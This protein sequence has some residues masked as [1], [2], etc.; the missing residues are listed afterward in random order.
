MRPG[1]KLS[2]LQ[3]FANRKM[4]DHRQHDAGTQLPALDQFDFHSRL[5]DA[6]GPVLVMFTSPDC[7]GCRHLRGV[8]FEVR[9]RHPEWRYFEVDAQRDQALTNEFEV[10]HLPTLFLFHAGQFH[11][12][13]ETEA[14]P[15]AIIAAIRAALR[16][17]A[18]EAP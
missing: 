1:G 12:Q 2:L 15:A 4:A 7:G 11:C 8:L 5:A 17:P 14:R 9:R 3:D 13:L 16:Q 10:F 18:E 6:G